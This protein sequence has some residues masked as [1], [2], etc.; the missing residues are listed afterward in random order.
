M[1]YFTKVNYC[2]IFFSADFVAYGNI[3]LEVKAQVG[4]LDTHYK[5]VINYLAVSKCPIA[6][7][8][9]FGEPSLKFKRVALLQNKINL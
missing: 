8:V 6:L 5:Q 9:N 4:A 3:I 7:L 1:K 2:R